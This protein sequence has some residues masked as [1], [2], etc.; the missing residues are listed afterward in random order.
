MIINAG[1]RMNGTTTRIL[2]SFTHHLEKEY[3]TELIDLGASPIAPCR[4][5]NA[6]RPDGSCVLKHDTGTLR[7]IRVACAAGG[8]KVLSETIFDAAWR[9]ESGDTKL[10]ARAER[11]FARR[12]AR[13]RIV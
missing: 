1:P 6:C 4:G 8:V 2:E 10:S 5:C 3:T 7:A 13:I 11:E 9:L 12:I